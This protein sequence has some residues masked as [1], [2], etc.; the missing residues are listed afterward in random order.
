MKITE[1]IKENKIFFITFG[2]LLIVSAEYL[3]QKD[4]V[5]YMDNYYFPLYVINYDCGFSSRLLVGAIFSLF[6]GETLNAATIVR[7]LLGMYVIVCFLLSLFANN[8][9]KKTKYENLGIYTVFLAIVPS[10]VAFLRY[11]GTLDIFW[12]VFI[13]LSLFL[14]DKKG[15]RWLVPIF[16]AICFAV[17][18]LFATTYLPVM[19]IAVF[20]QFVK[21]QNVANFVYIAA[22]ALIVGAAAIY[23]LFIGDST[24]TMTSDQMVEFARGRLDSVGSGFGDPYL[25]SVFYWEAPGTNE[26]SGFLGYIQYNF[27]VFAMDDSSFM[28]GNI[29]FVL[30]NALATIPFFYLMG[31]AFKKAAK[32]LEKFVFLCSFSTFPFMFINLLLSTDTDR[33]S[34][35]FLLACLFLM[36]FFIKE[37]NASFSE[38]YDE[39]AEKIDKNKAA[40]AIIGVSAARII[41]SGVRF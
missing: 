26:Y 37:N 25:R 10:M 30:S 23:F 3:A 4:V 7:L 9:L 5:E 15:F 28:K 36:L 19:A 40:V 38:S 2:I 39:A 1:R 32:P 17:Y 31:K 11:L 22:S 24:L 20:Y 16:C 6:F 14:V 41:L 27:N 33:F 8:Y 35:H 13:F 34:M 12:M 21:K 29:Y 18:E